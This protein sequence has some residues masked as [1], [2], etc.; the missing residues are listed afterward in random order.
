M[1]MYMQP[2]HVVLVKILPFNCSETDYSF[3]EDSSSSR[4]PS[5]TRMRVSPS[6][7]LTPPHYFFSLHH[8]WKLNSLQRADVPLE[9]VIGLQ[10]S[11]T[12]GNE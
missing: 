4:T 9:I 5:S 1:K 8:P 3:C 2:L 10:C 12:Y 6:D 11:V 7:S